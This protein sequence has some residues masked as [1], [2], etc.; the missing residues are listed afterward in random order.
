MEYIDGKPL[1]H[2]CDENK[3]SINERLNIFRQICDAVETAHKNKVIHRDLKPSNILV[4][5]DGT[6]KLLDFGIAKVL[7]PEL[8]VT[9]IDPTAT[10][11]RVMTPEYASPEQVSGDEITPASDIY[12]L[13]IILYELLTGHRPYRLKRQVP[14]EVARIICEEMP[15][16]P[17]GNLTGEDNLVPIT[18][19]E[20]TTLDFIFDARNSSLNELQKTLSGELD[21]IVLKT[22]R[23]KTSERYKSAAALAEDITNFLENR[24][25]KA[26]AFLP[27]KKKT[28]NKKSVAI[29]PLKIIG[30]E[31]SKNTEDIFLGIGLADALVSRLSGVQRLIVRPTSSVLPFRGRKS[32]R[33]RKKNRC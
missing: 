12:S 5:K 11:M 4:K 31:T 1:Y 33:S 19:K 7:D 2:F 9:D 16:R 23:K 24:P 6:P 3:L 15:S 18:D 26:E 20:K 27:E 14:H 30:A 8:A 28:A 21:K 22:L 17:S 10:S 25:V 32:A 29:L 13:G